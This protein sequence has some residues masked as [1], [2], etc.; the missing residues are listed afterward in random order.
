MIFL[1]LIVESVA[2]GT[3]RSKG[4]LLRTAHGIL[5]S[6]FLCGATY[7]ITSQL[8]DASSPLLH[9]HTHTNILSQRGD[10]GY[11]AVT[12]GRVVI[13]TA[14]FTSCAAIRDLRD[15]TRNATPK[16]VTTFLL[17]CFVF[18][19]LCGLSGVQMYGGH[20]GSRCVYKSEVLSSVAKYSGSSR[21]PPRP[22]I[23][24]YVSYHESEG[25]ICPAGRYDIEDHIS[26]SKSLE[27]YECP[28]GQVCM[29]GGY[30]YIGPDTDTHKDVEFS[31]E[32]LYKSS[33]SVFQVSPHTHNIAYGAQTHVT[34]GG[35][36]RL[37]E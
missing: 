27:P 33:L 29:E 23:D 37:T 3:I 2:I 18:L 22:V 28:E 17:W 14:G 30:P 32:N 11:F 24:P 36:S 8:I 13:Q 19:L 21:T 9:A 1:E 35:T 10:A 12:L 5:N 31:F 4:A 34:S 7:S 20:L 6:L 26:L 15:A 16:L 25:R